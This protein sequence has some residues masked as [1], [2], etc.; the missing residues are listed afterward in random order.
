MQLLCPECG[1]RTAP[2]WPKIREMAVTSQASKL[3]TQ[4]KLRCSLPIIHV[5]LAHV[6]SLSI[7]ALVEIV[8]SSNSI[9]LP[10]I[11]L[12][13]LFLNCY[14]STCLLSVM[15]IIVLQIIETRTMKSLKWKWLYYISFI[16]LSWTQN[17]GQEMYFINTGMLHNTESF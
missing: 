6:I 9:P 11:Y 7:L 2:N 15:N 10:Q 3:A 14:F 12:I 16:R 1:L 13:Q 17:A 5:F 8:A 4:K